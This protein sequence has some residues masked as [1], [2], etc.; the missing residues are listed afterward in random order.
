[1]K[2]YSCYPFAPFLFD[3]AFSYSD[4]ISFRFVVAV[5]KEKK[6]LYKVLAITKDR[7]KKKKRGNTMA[8]TWTWYSRKKRQMFHREVS[9]IGCCWLLR[10]TE[11]NQTH[12]RRQKQQPSWLRRQ[13]SPARTWP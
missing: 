2:I 12:P 13:P 5:E 1:M 6:F 10:S 8:L 4:S 11:F 7:R 9:W 3:F